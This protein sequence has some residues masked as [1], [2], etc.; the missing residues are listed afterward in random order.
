M[1]VT[2]GIIERS[3]PPDL[4]ENGMSSPPAY[5]ASGSSFTIWDEA[6]NQGSGASSVQ[7]STRFYLSLDAV[8]GSG[9]ILLDGVRTVP[10]MPSGTTSGT[11]A[12]MLTI[13]SG[14]PSGAYYLIACVDD[15]GEILEGN[16]GNNCLASVTTISVCVAPGY[17]SVTPWEDFSSSGPQGG[18]FS[19]SSTTY[20]LTNPGGCPLDWT[21]SKGQAWVS[22]SKTGGTLASGAS[23]DV[24]VSITSNANALPP[25][26]Y[27]DEVF[28]TNT[29]N[30][31]GNTTKE[32]N[33]TVNP[34]SPEI[35]LDNAPAGQSG[36]GRSYTGTWVKSSAS[37]AYGPDSLYS[38]GSGVDTYRWTPTIPAAGTYEVYVRWTAYSTRSASVPIAVTHAG[39]TTTKTYDQRTGGGVW[40]LHGTYG[41]NAG[42]GGYVQ[43]SDVNG[44]ACADVVKFVP[45]AAL[46]TVTVTATDPT[47][48]EN[49]LDT[50]VF[51]VSRT[52]GTATALT[53]SY[54]VG[55]TATPGS[56]YTAL[57]GSVTI[58]AG[59]ATATVTVTPVNDTQVEGEETVVLTLSAGAGYAVGT[60]GSATITIA[61][62]DVGEIILDNAPAGQSGGGRSYTGTWLKSSASGAYGP[63]S[64]YSNGSGVDTYRWTPTIPAAGTY[65]V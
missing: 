10:P 23:T 13:P 2:M 49:P 20:T 33:L 25:G 24:I 14:T 58:L 54:T 65:E 63:D 4:I 39:G 37:G 8:K 21:A 46:P 18:P 19:P 45:A 17:I 59:S 29:T 28:F 6:M 62:D 11:A 3:Q 52:G 38:N 9:D 15:L 47:A 42:T 51:T 5:A 50:G 64:L 12:T 34:S 41:F 55:G 35:I 53:V 1:A 60:P 27:G 44:Q 7:S 48:A 61:S 56:D 16:E 57:G 31:N 40:V 43:V 26:A 30:G 22:L 36:G 32:V